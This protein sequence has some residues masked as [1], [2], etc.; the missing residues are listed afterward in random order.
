[1]LRSL[2]L[3]ALA[4]ASFAQIGED[5]VNARADARA[6]GRS[7][8]PD[9]APQWPSDPDVLLVVIDDMGWEDLELLPTQHLD[10]LAARGRAFTNYYVEPVCTPT[11]LSLLAGIYATREDV[12]SALRIRTL[13]K[14]GLDADRPTLA[15]S[16]NGRGW[17]T[18]CFGKWHMSTSGGGRTL[19]SA[20]RFGFEDWIA[21]TEGSIGLEGRSTH[22]DWERIDEGVVTRSRTYSALAITDAFVE[23]WQATEGP[24]P[25]F[26]TINYLT[27]HEPWTTPPRELVPNAASYGASRR[28]RFEQS[29]VALDTLIGRVLDTVDLAST[30]VVVLADNGTPKEVPPPSL[31]YRGYKGTSWQGGVNVPLIVAGPGVVPGTDD[32]LCHAVDLPVTLLELCGV[33]PSRGFEDGV[34]FAAALAGS[35]M[36]P[37]APVVVGYDNSDRPLGDGREQRWNWAVIEASGLKLVFDD[38]TLEL[39]DLSTDPREGRPLDRP[40]DVER[41]AGLQVRFRQ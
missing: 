24:R 33:A 34:G 31:R 37:R 21:G 35:T 4:L 18:A 26:A 15:R 9:A 36:V 8:T 14:P 22:D 20:R 28:G 12:S 7:P 16:L 5:R 40:T 25:R 32:H 41:L 2:F 17:R 1:M 6:D 27:P 39:F 19:E 30:F 29:V 23:W 3:G 10:A 38:G 13:E 11:R